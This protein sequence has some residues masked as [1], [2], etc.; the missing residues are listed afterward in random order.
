ME[1]EMTA[2]KEA[3]FQV[4]EGI[5]GLKDY[6]VNVYMVQNPHDQRWVLV[7][8]GLKR[9]ASKIRK[10][11][12]SLFGENSRPEAILL[13]HGHFDHVGAL[14]ELAEEWDV[15]VYAHEMELPY[16]TGR[17]SY[18]PPDSTVGG[19]MMAW[20]A[21]LY[22]KAPINIRNRVQQ[23]PMDESVPGL[24]GWKYIHTPGHAPGHVSFWREKDKVLIVG[25]AFVTTQQE[26]A[27]AVMMQTEC[28][29]GPP[30]YFTYDWTAAE[31][32]VKKLAELRPEVVATGHGKPMSG[33]DMQEELTELVAH[34]RE[35]AVPT[36]GRY[37][38]RPAIVN[39]SGVVFVPPVEDDGFSLPMRIAGV[40]GLVA[41]GLV[42]YSKRRKL[43][44]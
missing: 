20:M 2:T 28:L 44:A 29:T 34:F 41:L 9:S 14:K 40:A 33:R 8:A 25:D 31:N 24:P 4:A 21:D 12:R 19:G 30:M 32:S 27:I 39:A 36:K 35:I 13:T 18:P 38:D 17:A 42:L 5:W 11:A 22:P 7:D 16:L 26:S 43:S 10:M 15:T 37:K 23:L 6:F 3:Y 1:N